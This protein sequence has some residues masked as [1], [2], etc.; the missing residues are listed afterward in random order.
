MRIAIDTR[1]STSEQS[2]D[3]QVRELRAYAK[4]REWKIARVMG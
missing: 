1:V 4:A 3:R 2:T